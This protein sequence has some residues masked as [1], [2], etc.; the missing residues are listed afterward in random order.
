M[1]KLRAWRNRFSPIHFR[2]STRMRCITAICAAGPPKLRSATRVHTQKASRK[3]TPCW[4]STPR[5]AMA[6]T[7]ISV[8]RSRLLTA[9]GIERV[10]DDHTLRQHRVVIGEVDLEALRYREQALGLRRQVRAACVGAADNQR[11]MIE[12]RIRQA[13]GSDESIEAAELA[14]MTELYVRNVVRGR[15]PTLGRLA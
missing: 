3:L 6:E 10:I 13:V 5:A 8:F 14:V 11:E 12:R 1:Q 9:P 4:C 15:A 2:S 7:V